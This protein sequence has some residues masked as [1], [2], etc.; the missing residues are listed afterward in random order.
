MGWAEEVGDGSEFGAEAYD[1][2]THADSELVVQENGQHWT[3]AYEGVLEV[4]NV[5]SCSQLPASGS[6][7]FYPN[8]VQYGYPGHDQTA[9]P[10]FTGEVFQSGCNN[11]T[12][13]NN[14][15]DSLYL[16]F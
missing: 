5:T 4:Y 9:P 16:Y 10:A 7:Y 3:W 15:A 1:N 11:S 8:F 12:V 2:N 6:V 14:S 13:V